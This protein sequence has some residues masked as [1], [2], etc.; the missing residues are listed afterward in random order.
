MLIDSHVHL[1]D[2]K[3]S[4]D[5]DRVLDR[6]EDAGIEW[7]VV[8]G[9]RIESSRKAVELA[10]GH[11]S[12]SVVVGV[13]PHHADQFSPSELLELDKLSRHEGVVAIGEIGLDYHYPGFN[14]GRQKECFLAQA[15]LAARRELPLVL[16]CRDAYDDLLETIRRDER[17]PRRGIIHCFSG[18]HEQACAFIDMGFYLG[19]GG[20]ITYPNGTALR[21]LV[22]RVALE[23]IVCET[24]APYLP[25]QCKRGRRNEPSYMKHT[26]KAL[27]DLSGL[28]FQDAA[29]ITKANAVRVFDLPRRIDATLTYQI[30]KTLYLCITNRCTNDCYFCQRCSDYMVMGHFL[31]LGEEPEAQQLLDRIEDPQAY[32]EIVLSG[33][34]EPTLRWDVCLETARRLK[35]QGSRVRLNTNGCGNLINGRNIIPEMAG[36]VDAVAINLVAHDQATYNRIGRPQDPDRAWGA[37]REFTTI[38]KEYVPDVILTIIAVPEVDVEACRVLAED[39]LEVRLRVREYCPNGYPRNRCA[40]LAQDLT[41]K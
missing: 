15:H 19:I 34:G 17:V 39:Q 26:I 31:Q 20:A 29:R 28:S 30:R 1:Q 10:R 38:C 33:L 5:L 37:M 12:V 24:D 25:P 7:L 3:F 2:K 8:I 36:L 32:H 18:T 23:R 4:R 40:Q 14:S 41:K 6:A 11:R 27:A 13:H 16:H 9:D 35:E 21:E 22:G